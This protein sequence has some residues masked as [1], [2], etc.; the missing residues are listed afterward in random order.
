MTPAQA[1]DSQTFR[2]KVD[3]WGWVGIATIGLVLAGL[4]WE[5]VTGL[6]RG[7]V[8][9]WAAALLPLIP[10]TVLLGVF[11]PIRYRLGGEAL[12]L[13]AGVMR[14]PISYEAI[15][16]VRKGSWRELCSRQAVHSIHW[17][18]FATDFLVVE[19]GQARH[20]IRVRPARQDVFLAEL[21]ARA[22]LMEAAGEL[23]RPEST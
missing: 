19:H 16:C 12:E 18:G 15:Q 2:P 8:A 20:H 11:L 9:R 17:G 21:A 4:V 22:N 13:R 3:V 14:T 1:S 23:K 7:E 6:M 10:I 5:F